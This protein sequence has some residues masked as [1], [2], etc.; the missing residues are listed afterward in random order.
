[1][2]PSKS[3]GSA[4]ILVLFDGTGYRS[5]RRG[6]LH[7]ISVKNKVGFINGKIQKPAA[8]SP[9][10]AQWE[11]CDDM[12]TSWILNSLSKDL[13]DSLYDQTNGA[14]LYQLQQEINDLAQENLDITG[15]YSML[16]RLWE[17]LNT[18]DPNTQCTCLCTCGGKT[19]MHKAEQ[20]RKLIQFLMGL[21]E[22]YTIVREQEPNGNVYRGPPNQSQHV[23]QT[24]HFPDINR[25]NLFCDYCKK[26]GHTEEKCYRLHGFPQNFKF[27]RGR[28]SGSAASAHAN[29]DAPMDQDQGTQ[30]LTKDQYDHLV[31]LLESV[32]VQGP[33]S[34]TKD[35]LDNIMSRAASFAV[36]CLASDLK[37]V[38]SFND[39]S[40][41]LQGPSLKSPLVIGRA[42][43]GL[44]FF[45]SRCPTVITSSTSVP[46]CSSLHAS[47]K[48]ALHHIPSSVTSVIPRNKAACCDINSSVI[49]VDCP[50]P[51]KSF[52]LC[53]SH[54][55][56]VDYLWHTR[57]GHV[58][59]VK[60]RGI[61]TIPVKFSP[62]LPFLCNVCPMARQARMPFPSNSTPSSTKIFDLLHIDLLGPYHTPTY[63]KYKYFITIVNDYSRST[64]TQLISSKSNTLQTIKAFTSLI[65]N[66]FSTTI[67]TIR[68]DNGL[69]FVNKETTIFLQAKGIIHQRTCP[70]TP[71]QNGVVERKHKYL[72]E[73]ARSLLYQSKLSMSYWGKC[74]LTATYLVN[75]LPS[76]AIQNK[77]PFE[78][79]YQRPPTY[80]HLRS[81]GC[82]CFPTTLKTHKDKFE[83]QSTPHVF[84]GYP[85]NTKGYKVLDLS[86]KQ[87]HI[88]RDVL[89]HENIFP[90]AVSFPD[91]SFNSV[92]RCLDVNSKLSNCTNSTLNNAH[93]LNENNSITVTD[94]TINAN[95]PH[96]ETSVNE[97]IPS[98]SP[99]ISPH[100]TISTTSS[101]QQQPHA[102]RRSSRTHSVPKYLNEYNYNLPNLQPQS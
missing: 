11:R 88:S 102:P 43:N 5:W 42:R 6:V 56:N 81:F 47:N 72:L 54:E 14:K 39:I 2:H 83:P 28:N 79:L 52:S 3:A 9:T 84:I 67:K 62:K 31:R 23:N 36:H 91:S 18:L 78:V 38:I 10:F 82:L 53:T 44:Y 92:L 17:E 25:E 12:V 101:S 21:N 100:I 74:I 63:N 48:Q 50:E 93:D 19:K 49:H 66:Q 57:L 75:R 20:D 26:A 4:I 16:R 8:N 97:T 98:D 58:P 51:T 29:C 71:Q 13:A 64:W 89:F 70:Y 61:H 55:N 86:T 46:N 76:I 37:S 7:A 95:L 41:S 68:T 27:T 1:M 60:M 15:Y 22:V 30:S 32:Q 94:N 59:F 33:S 35:T 73:T 24:Y 99:E 69:E 96:I 77:T 87:I 40:C 34:S 85:F 65:E 45:Y 90:F 80:S